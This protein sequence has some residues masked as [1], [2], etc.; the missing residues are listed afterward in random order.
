MDC[1][2]IRMGSEVHTCTASWPCTRNTLFYE[3]E[4]KFS[5][6]DYFNF[7]H[8]IF[9]KSIVSEIWY[10]PFALLENIDLILAQYVCIR[11]V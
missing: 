4:C 6:E 3:L 1:N 5:S 7:I 9:L 8:E 2:C 10:V 11:P